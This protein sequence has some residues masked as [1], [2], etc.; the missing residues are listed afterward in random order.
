MI[1]WEVQHLTLCDGWINVTHD[2]EG[3]L[4]QFDTEAEAVNDLQDFMHEVKDAVDRGDM[5]EEYDA[6]EWRVQAVEVKDG[7]V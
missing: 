6:S 2:G 4:L 5:D 3:H 1:K 7:Q